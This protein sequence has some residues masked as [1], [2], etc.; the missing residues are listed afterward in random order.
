MSPS[1]VSLAQGEE[2]YVTFSGDA[3]TSVIEL[4]TGELGSIS[5]RDGSVWKVFIPDDSNDVDGRIFSE[6]I[7]FSKSSGILLRATKSAEFVVHDYLISDFSRGVVLGGFGDEGVSRIIP[8]SA[9][10]ADE[11]L[12]I[13]QP[14][15][16]VDV[17]EES[18]ENGSAGK[19]TNI[20]API[21]S[22]Y[23][24]EFQQYSESID[25]LDGQDLTWPIR[26]SKRAYKIVVHH[27]ASDARDI[28]DDGRVNADDYAMQI[29]GIYNFHTV[30]RG[31]GDVGYNFLVDPQGNVYEGR[32]GRDYKRM[33]V[34]A[35]V[36][37]QNTGTIGIALLGNF[38]D[39]SVPPRQLESLSML[40][41]DLSREYD[42]DPFGSSK[43]RGA[44]LPNVVGHKDI[45]TVTKKLIGQGAT[46]CPGTNLSAS[47]TRAVA[48]VKEYLVLDY[49]IAFENVPEIV[50]LV[51]G[52]SDEKWELRFWNRGRRDLSS[53][54][55][56]LGNGMQAVVGDVK[57]GEMAVATFTFES[58]MDFLSEKT[59]A[60]VYV[61]D[62]EG[63]RRVGR[64]ALFEIR[65]E[66]GFVKVAGNPSLLLN[67]E[68]LYLGGET[69]VVFRYPVK[70]NANLSPGRF[71]V[72]PA[73]AQAKRYLLGGANASE[74]RS[75]DTYVDIPVTFDISPQN[76]ARKG[77]SVRVELSMRDMKIDGAARGVVLDGVQ[78]DVQEPNL[79]SKT[80]VLQG[81]DT[82]FLFAVR[83]PKEIRF[84]IDTT[85]LSASLLSDL[86]DGDISLQLSSS[87]K[88]FVLEES[89]IPFAL[90]NDGRTLTASVAVDSKRP[91]LTVLQGDVFFGDEKIP[92]LSGKKNGFSHKLRFKRESRLKK[93]LE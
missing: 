8:R 78:F 44:V 38:N 54:V 55:V 6:P 4:T 13:Y 32:A 28:N 29:R 84:D 75:G 87:N 71:R 16:S 24:D 81:K 90:M 34:G 19:R 51:P 39:D 57:A 67:G 26:Y 70:T 45:G 49:D 25:T 79:S 58:S 46:S 73:N 66:K 86:A 83:E 27:T 59:N 68:K 76:R 77:T 14:E 2:A 3:N 56:K 52:D 37:C 50:R 88:R 91:M 63:F 42:I 5:Y 9:W 31:W 60:R 93:P 72:I 69:S 80:M 21:E 41:A 10:G 48:L 22:A 7:F 40:I 15:V 85:G 12:R 33:P 30:T 11:G 62:E 74:V 82:E 64:T 65:R 36:L 43:F 17:I 35:H 89:V 23:P 61:K 92:S 18:E 53:T 47:L 20:C 1:E